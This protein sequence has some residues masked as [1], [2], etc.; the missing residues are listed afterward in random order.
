MITAVET[1]LAVRR[2]A[3]FALS[4]TEYLLHSFARFA[5]A[6]QET[7]I[8]TATAIEWAS[9]SVSVAQRHTRYQTVC[10]ARRCGAGWCGARRCAGVASGGHRGS[11]QSA[12]RCARRATGAR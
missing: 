8:R 9:A 2:A 5:A 4:N 7:H 6:R 11:R 1:Y 12:R 3:G 10:R